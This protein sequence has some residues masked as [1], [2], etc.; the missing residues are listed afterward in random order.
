MEKIKINIA[1]E[2]FSLESDNLEKV[3]MFQEFIDNNLEKAKAIT[4]LNDS[5][6]NLAYAYLSLTIEM[7]ENIK[8]AFN[9]DDDQ[10]SAKSKIELLNN[11]LQS[12]IEELNNELGK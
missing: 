4:H 12:K 5:K 1:G 8:N 10:P 6:T 7:W 2:S 9:I 11:K 3:K